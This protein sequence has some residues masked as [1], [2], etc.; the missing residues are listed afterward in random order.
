M[1]KLRDIFR[2]KLRPRMA[3]DFDDVD[4]EALLD[5][6]LALIRQHKIEEQIEEAEYVARLIDRGWIPPEE[7]G[8]KLPIETDAITY[9]Q[10]VLDGRKSKKVKL[11]EIS[12]E[13]LDIYRY[14]QMNYKN[15]VKEARRG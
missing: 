14:A 8:L 3:D 7:P 10:G 13:E 2:K 9:T 1:D 11:P 5:D 15:K 4:M 12:A 6:L